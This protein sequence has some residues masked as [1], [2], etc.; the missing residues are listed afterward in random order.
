MA[1]LG[2]GLGFILVAAALPCSPSLV[3]TASTLRLGTAVRC[4]V[5]GDGVADR[6]LVHGQGSRGGWGPFD[7]FE[8]R[9]GK[10]RLAGSG[11]GVDST[12]A[13][14]D[15]DRADARLEIAITQQGASDEYE[16]RFF[17]LDGDSILAM[18]ELPGTDEMTIDG[19]GIV[20]TMARGRILHTW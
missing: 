12:F 18:G 19:S 10:A 3:P 5:D 4:D 20:R 2:F 16:T 6:I 14:V 9:I 1:P 13:L 7:D 8:V 15:I 11:W 17:T